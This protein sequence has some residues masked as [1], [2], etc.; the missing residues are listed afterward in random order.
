MSPRP[1]RV[2]NG[3][4]FPV[5]T[6]LTIFDSVPTTQRQVDKLRVVPAAQTS[7]HGPGIQP[8]GENS[9]GCYA[10]RYALREDTK[11]DIEPT[12]VW[13]LDRDLS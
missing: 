4:R 5:P 11:T 2:H 13:A 10:R 1:T 12:Y 8:K 3:D 9:T 6:S 7:L